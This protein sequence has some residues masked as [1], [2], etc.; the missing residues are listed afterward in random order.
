M[1]E[2]YKVRDQERPYFIT[3]ATLEW[4][5]VFTRAQYKDIIVESLK[6][7]QQ[8]KG[9]VLYAWCLM[10]NHIHLIIGRNG[11]EN[12]ESII[13]DFKKYTSVMV[14]RAIENNEAESRKQWMLR[15]FSGAALESKKH[16]KYKFWQDSYHPVELSTNF[17]MDQKLDYI[18]NNPVKD[19]VVDKPEEYCYSSARNYCGL[20]GLLK[21]SFMD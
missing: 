5:D 7:C 14:M 15:L 19:G 3:F 12:I 18:H 4:V 17:L 21:V 1:S 11:E 16:Q 2:K 8:Q 6:H 13:R 20:P 10:T 9:M